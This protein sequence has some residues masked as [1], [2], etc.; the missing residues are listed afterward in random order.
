MHDIVSH[1]LTVMIALADGGD[2]RDADTRPSKRRRRS[3]VLSATG[4]HALGEMRR[5]LGVLRDEPDGEPLEPQPRLDQLDDLI[6]RVEAAGVPVSLELQG[7]PHALDEGVQVTVFRVAQEALTNTLKHAAGRR[8]P[9][10]AALR[11][12]GRLTSR[13][14]TPAPTARGR[15]PP[16]H[17]RPRPA[18][19]A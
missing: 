1:N 16:L 5:L 8:A 3:N 18:R 12:R 7:D 17:G 4:R 2:V 9:T 13:S 6:A 14:P 10:G 11:R 19:D 15:Q